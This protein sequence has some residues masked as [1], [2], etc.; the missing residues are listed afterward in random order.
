[1]AVALTEVTVG[2][3]IKVEDVLYVD[4]PEGHARALLRTALNPD[5]QMVLEEIV[6]IK[7]KTE[8]FW[9]M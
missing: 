4:V 9:A 2:R 5:D 7:R 3:Q 1:V 6:D 8:P